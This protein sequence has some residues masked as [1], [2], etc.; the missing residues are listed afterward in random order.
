[1][2]TELTLTKTHY[3]IL[4]GGMLGG[5]LHWKYIWGPVVFAV[6]DSSSLVSSL[7]DFFV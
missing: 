4:Y 7:E 6:F 2:I 5:V 1:M 3:D